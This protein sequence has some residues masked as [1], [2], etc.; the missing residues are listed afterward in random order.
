MSSKKLKIPP[1]LGGPNEARSGDDTADAEDQ[2]RHKRADDSLTRRN[3]RPRDMWVCD[4][5]RFLIL[6]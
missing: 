5:H 4:P 6:Q 3:G 2:A 1:L